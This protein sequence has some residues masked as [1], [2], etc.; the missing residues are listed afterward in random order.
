MC[1]CHPTTAI[2]PCASHSLPFPTRS[3][4]EPTASHDH[5]NASIRPEFRAEEAAFEYWYR[6]YWKAKRL[7][8]RVGTQSPVRPYSMRSSYRLTVLVFTRQRTNSST[9]WSNVSL[10]RLQ[11][12]LATLGRSH[13]RAGWFSDSQQAK[14]TK[15]AQSKARKRTCQVSFDS[16]PPSRESGRYPP[17]P[18][19]ASYSRAGCTSDSPAAVESAAASTA[20][21]DRHLLPYGRMI[22]SH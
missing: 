5:L 2:H 9:S 11:W 17:H 8:V 22:T 12:R 16:P 7:N 19:R 1:R 4:V 15:T 6:A 21:V 3:Q 13:A 14:Q 10:H 18:H 20:F